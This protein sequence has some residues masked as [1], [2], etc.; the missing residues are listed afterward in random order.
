MVS[1]VYCLKSKDRVKVTLVEGESPADGE[2]LEDQP[3]AFECKHLLHETGTAVSCR[4]NGDRARR[5]SPFSYMLN[6]QMLEHDLETQQ[7][8]R[9]RRG[10]VYKNK[11]EI[12]VSCPDQYKVLG[13]S[14]DVET[15][16]KRPLLTVE[17][18]PA[19]MV[20]SID[21]KAHLDDEFV[22]RRAKPWQT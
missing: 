20:A 5:C 4:I 19:G 2:T 12:D 13:A 6:E 10:N 17:F 21:L 14:Y 1:S 7:I 8:V 18:L 16:G 3:Y 9:E 11:S 22:E 15:F